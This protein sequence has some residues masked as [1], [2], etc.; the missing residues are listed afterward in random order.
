MVTVH[1]NI[2]N[3]QTEPLVGA[4]V[5][6]TRKTWAGTWVNEGSDTTDGNGYYSISGIDALSDI[7]VYADAEGYIPGMATD[8]INISDKRVDIVL[9]REGETPESPEVDIWTR[10]QQFLNQYW[11]WIML[12]IIVLVILFIFIWLR[13]R[14]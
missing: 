9:M 14:G 3:K 11:L 5:Y 12:A 7:R 6:I 8:Y 10:L 1:G 2:Y 4:P 13:R